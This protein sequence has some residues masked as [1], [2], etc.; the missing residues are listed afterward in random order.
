MR[1]FVRLVVILWVGLLALNACGSGGASQTADPQDAGVITARAC[2]E[3]EGRHVVLYVQNLDDFEWGDI[4]IGVSKG[5]ETYSQELDSLLPESQA[6]AEPFTESRDFFY[7][8]GGAAQQPGG[9]VGQGHTRQSDRYNLGS[10][11]HIES[12]EVEVQLPS[13]ASWTGE[14][15]PCE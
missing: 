5:G 14:A 7:Y 15:G 10:F 4:R 8:L 11:S 13:E 1:R 12:V 3:G 2:T 6:E 9:K